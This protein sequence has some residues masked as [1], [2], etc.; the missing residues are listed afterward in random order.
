MKTPSPAPKGRSVKAFFGAERKKKKKKGTNRE[1][2]EKKTS[3]ILLSQGRRI[4]LLKKEKA[5]GKNPK[6]RKI[7]SQILK[8]PRWWFRK[9][10]ENNKLLDLVESIRPKQTK[11]IR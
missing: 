7:S 2:K 9:A 5:G 11:Q 10:R 8:Q 3:S 1:K 4:M 6:L